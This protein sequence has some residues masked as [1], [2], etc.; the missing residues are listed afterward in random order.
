MYYKILGGIHND[1][2]PVPRL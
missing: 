1:V 2:L